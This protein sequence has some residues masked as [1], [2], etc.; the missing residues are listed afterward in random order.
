MDDSHIFPQRVLAALILVMG[1]LEPGVQR[2]MGLPLCLVSITILLVS[3]CSQ[4]DGAEGLFIRLGLAL[5]SLSVCFPSLHT[6]V[7]V[8]I[9]GNA[10]T[11]RVCVLMEFQYSACVG[12]FGSS[13]MQATVT[14]SVS[15]TLD[16][17][18]AVSWSSWGQ[19]IHTAWAGVH[20]EVVMGIHNQYYQTTLNGA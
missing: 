20:S 6:G 12:I 5:I 16:L 15:A 18:Q 10:E 14:S 4:V 7:F 2:D 1:Q 9:K 19:S 11:I 8:S 3:C 17:C 13:Q